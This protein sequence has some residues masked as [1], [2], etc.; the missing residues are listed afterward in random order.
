MAVC[1][2]K[3]H[4]DRIGGIYTGSFNGASLGRLVYGLVFSCRGFC[5][6]V[7]QALTDPDLSDDMLP[8]LSCPHIMKLT[9]V[10]LTFTRRI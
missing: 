3:S 9:Q 10:I 6:E 8:Y 4:D 7:H 1:G 2:I 5:I